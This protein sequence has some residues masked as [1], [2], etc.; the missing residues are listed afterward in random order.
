LLIALKFG[1]RYFHTEGG[2]TQFLLFIYVAENGMVLRSGVKAAIDVGEQKIRKIIRSLGP[3]KNYKI[4]AGQKPLD[5]I[6]TRKHP[7]YPNISV[8]ELTP[9]GVGIYNKLLEF[10]YNY[11]K[12]LQ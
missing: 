4:V 6:R 11:K 12:E 5:Y 3:A 1:H 2:V 7:E 9:K 10:I 8:L